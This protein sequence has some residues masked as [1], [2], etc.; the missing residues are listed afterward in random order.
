MMTTTTMRLAATPASSAAQAK[1]RKVYANSATGDDEIILVEQFDRA[2]GWAPHPQKT[3]RLTIDEALKLADDLVL[4]VGTPI[5][6]Q[7]RR[8]S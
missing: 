8:K 1:A 2:S 6:Q 3:L 4:A 7:V 5:A